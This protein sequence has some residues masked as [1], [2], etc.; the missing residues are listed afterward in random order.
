VVRSPEAVTS[1]HERHPRAG[2]WLAQRYPSSPVRRQT[3]L[4][5]Y[6]TWLSAEQLAAIHPRLLLGSLVDQQVKLCWIVRRPAH[7]HVPPCKRQ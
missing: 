4:Q 5:S 2:D 1:C 6:P 3:S 7:G